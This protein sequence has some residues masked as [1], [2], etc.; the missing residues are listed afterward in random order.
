[1]PFGPIGIK[2]EEADPLP[3]YRY[4]NLLGAALNPS[5]KRAVDGVVKAQ[6]KCVITV[7]CEVVNHRQTA[8]RADRSA[9]NVPGLADVFGK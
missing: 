6:F 4:F 1:M 2:S 5:E 7:N 8:T 3:V 9:R